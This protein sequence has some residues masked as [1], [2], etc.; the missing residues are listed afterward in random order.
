MS[1][2]K[3]TSAS[4]PH[5]DILPKL[6]YDN[7]RIK[8]KLTKVPL[9]QD[10]VT[11]NHGPIGNIYIVYELISS[12]KNIN[13]TLQDCLFGTVKLTKNADID[14]YKYSGYGIGFDSR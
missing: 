9:K 14:K 6:V 11:Y 4:S 2:E 10:K 1:N 3:I 8:L 5:N 13:V 12:P 7:G